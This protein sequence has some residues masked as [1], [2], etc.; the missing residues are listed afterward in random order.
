MRDILARLRSERRLFAL[1]IVVALLIIAAVQ[2]LS[3]RP[4]STSPYA[5]NPPSAENAPQ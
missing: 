2:L 1:F 4:P 5:P 3:P